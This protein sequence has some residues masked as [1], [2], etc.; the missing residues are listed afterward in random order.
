MICASTLQRVQPLLSNDSEI[1][2]YTTAGS[3]QRLGKHVPKT[4]DTHATIQTILETMFST[5]SV[6]VVGG[7]EK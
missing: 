1:S 7:D 5:Q 6:R 2:K 3:K 4:T